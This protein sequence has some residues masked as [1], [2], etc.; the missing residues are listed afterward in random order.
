MKV[1]PV[2]GK[3]NLLVIDS[4][5]SYPSFVTFAGVNSATRSVARLT[6]KRYKLQVM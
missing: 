6:P 3:N 1:Q 5:S 4:V 2:V